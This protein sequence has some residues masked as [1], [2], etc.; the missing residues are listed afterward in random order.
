MKTPE[1]IYLK[2]YTPPAFFV[3]Q[4][5]L[6]FEIKEDLTQVNSR[7][8]IRK[9]QSIT[10]KSTPLVLDMDEFE[11]IS[12]IAGGMVLLPHE[13]T[14]HDGLFKIAN[15][16]D[17][18]ELE[19]TNILRPHEN[20]SL[21]GLYQSGTI[22][23]TQCEA[24]G[25]R[26]IT[27]FPDRP[28]VMAR[29]S[30]TIIADKTKYPVLLSNGNLVDYKELD[31]NRHFVRWED[32]FKKPS[33][34]FALVAGDIDHIEDTFTTRSGRIVD[35][36]IFS[37]R[38]NIDKCYH[39]MTSLKQAMEWDENRFGLEYDLDLYQIVAINDFN[40]GA[41]ENK[42][43]NIFNSKYVLADPLTATDE[44]FM[45]I[46]GVIG[47]EY[48]HN[49]TGNRVTLKNWFQLSL[50]EG[51]TVFRDQEFSSDLNSRAV[52]RISNVKNLRGQ[53][54]PEDAGPMTHPVMP[55][56]YIKMDNFYTMTVYEKG[57][58]LVRMIHQLIGEQNFKQGIDLYF[59]KF[60]GMAVTIEDFIGVMEKAS[61][62]DLEQFKLWYFQSGT[63]IVTMIRS[64]NPEIQQLE[65]T[66]QQKTLPDRNQEIKKPL[67][68]PIKF[69][70]LN[71]E[72]KNI[73][74]VN[75]KLLEL[76]KEKESFVFKNI[77]EKSVPSIFRQFSAPVKIQTDLTDE[78]LSFLMANDT[79]EFSR[80]DAAQNLFVKE[81][82]LIINA[83][84]SR[85]NL[86]VSKG[87]VAAFK[88]ALTDPTRDRACLA[89]TLSLPME[90]EI[91][92]H[93]DL[94]DV[95][96][97][98][99]ARLFLKQTIAGQMKDQ[100]LNIIDLCSK[101]DPLSIS[102]G[103]MAD[104]SLKNLCLSYL[105]SLKEP[106]NTMVI[107]DHYE[108]AKNMTDE[109][110]CFKILSEIDPDIKQKTV[111]K[112]YAKWKLDKLVLDKWFAVQAASP[113]PDTLE[114]VKS[115]TGHHDFSIKNPNKVRSLIYMFAMQNPINFH[116]KNGA[117]Y[118]F[119]ADQIILLDQ[120][121]HMVAA[122]LSSCFNLWKKYD[123]HR[124][125]LMQ[126]ELERI[127]STQ[128]LSKNVYEIISRAL[129]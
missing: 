71:A 106:E 87:L 72:G 70:I 63:P 109:L 69:E 92:N 101:S 39:A 48:F 25:F 59:E 30:C 32:P 95:N 82:K 6:T 68:I 16:P 14:A 5:D 123:D 112:F 11:I 67:H 4:A 24:Q 115:L 96:A 44:D 33:Y 46:Q 35:L 98:N 40:A 105:G 10:D 38:E 42:G 128:T 121:N 78:E 66:F 76:R 50:K 90:T 60:D 120:I 113:L 80:W 97:I 111:E 56:S 91:K 18:F 102:H 54:F 27:P 81:L 85:K 1:K 125:A 108:S 12:V 77:P 122:R 28:D 19:I 45:N 124:K 36:K 8:K 79:D 127:L 62:R 20:T 55:D 88:K 21:E 65:I 2:D 94:V 26:K 61:T 126:K 7:L 9:N 129:A 37:E 100:F 116:Q 22:L 52:K 110:A 83:I 93:F 29:Y 34:L 51:L 86:S 23:C 43:L 64:Y 119:V 31:N 53:Q 58:E 41:M 47:H 103:A 89:K 107:W 104:R 15:T 117:G 73:T 17:A 75:K 99:T 84:Q 13:Y 57:S 74:P 3:D 49:W 114:I 118:T